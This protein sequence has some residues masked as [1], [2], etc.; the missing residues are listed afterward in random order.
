MSNTLEG[1]GS[2]DNGST[3]EHKIWETLRTAYIEG[4]LTEFPEG[5]E[6]ELLHVPRQGEG[7]CHIALLSGDMFTDGEQELLIC[8][9]GA[10]EWVQRE[11]D[12]TQPYDEAAVV[13]DCKATLEGMEQLASERWQKTL[14]ALAR[15]YANGYTTGRLLG[16]EP[17]YSPN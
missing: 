16:E 14:E 6:V 1:N 4:S 10:I 17:P 15:R 12:P 7:N 3:S 11:S 9:K 13:Q 8:L 2:H 5:A